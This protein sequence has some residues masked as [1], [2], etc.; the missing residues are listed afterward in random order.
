MTSHESLKEFP[1][2]VKNPK[3]DSI[4]TSLES[5]IKQYS[6]QSNARKESVKPKK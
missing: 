6:L 3:T 1:K 4:N 5:K 2:S